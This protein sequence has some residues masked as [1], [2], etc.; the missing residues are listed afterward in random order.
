MSV[1]TPIAGHSEF[2]KPMKFRNSATTICETNG[3]RKIIKKTFFLVNLWNPYVY[4]K[5]FLVNI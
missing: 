4:Q 1:N 3:I 2:G 5:V